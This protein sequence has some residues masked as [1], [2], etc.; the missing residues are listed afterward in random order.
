MEFKKLLASQ[1]QKL[2]LNH[3]KKAEQSEDEI[4]NSPQ[5]NEVCSSKSSSALRGAALGTLMA[6]DYCIKETVVENSLTKIDDTEIDYYGSGR[7]SKIAGNINE[8]TA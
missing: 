5:L 1:F 4:N 2:P 6:S 3:S 7:V 8:K